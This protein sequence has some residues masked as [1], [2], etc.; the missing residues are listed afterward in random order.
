MLIT[1]KLTAFGS[2]D[3]PDNFFQEIMA[4]W[5]QELENVWL[6][7]QCL[8]SQTF[9][10]SCAQNRHDLLAKIVGEVDGTKCGKLCFYKHWA[11]VHTM[12][13]KLVLL[14]LLCYLEFQNNSYNSMSRNKTVSIIYIIYI[15]FIGEFEILE[16][17]PTSFMKHAPAEQEFWQQVYLI[18]IRYYITSSSYHKN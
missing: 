2:I 17:E 6:F 3:F 11:L 13:L 4:V 9:S 8:K 12:Q 1:I 15:L 7:V 14:F 5:A 10:N 16:L 18:T